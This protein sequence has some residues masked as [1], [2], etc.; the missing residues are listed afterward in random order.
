MRRLVRLITLMLIFTT[1][2]TISGII[3]NDMLLGWAVIAGQFGALMIT[4]EV[5]MA[6]KQEE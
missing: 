4:K 2:G 6:H 5:I 3:A 1:I